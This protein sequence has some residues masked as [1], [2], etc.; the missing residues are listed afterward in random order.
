VRPVIYKRAKNVHWVLNHVKPSETDAMGKH[1]EEPL[2]GYKKPARN[3]INSLVTRV[4]IQTDL[5]GPVCWQSNGCS[6]RLKH[7]PMSLGR[8]AWETVQ[9]SREKTLYLRWKTV[10]KLNCSAWMCRNVWAES[11]ETHVS[12]VKTCTLACW[13]TMNK[14]WINT[15]TQYICAHWQTHLYEDQATTSNCIQSSVTSHWVHCGVLCYYPW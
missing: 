13:E 4:T 9:M 3:V 5:D 14:K 2:L 12:A 10:F 11:A 8:T 6:T 1:G 15:G 7:E